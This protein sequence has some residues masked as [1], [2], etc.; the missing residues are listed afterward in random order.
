LNELSIPFEH[1]QATH[2]ESGNTANLLHFHGVELSEPMAFGIGGGIFFGYFPFIR[3]AHIRVTTFRKAPMAVFFN[4]LKRLGL[5]YKTK[6][7]FSRANARKELDRVLDSGVPVG[8]QVGFYW[9]PYVPRAMRSHF[10]AH[11]IVVYGRKDGHYTISEPGMDQPQ[12]LLPED[13]ER[14]RFAKGGMNPNGRMYWLTEDRSPKAPAL[15]WPI[16]LG[17]RDACFNMLDIPIPLLG[18]KGIRYLGKDLRK[19]KQKLPEAEVMNNL[20]QIIIMQEVVGSGGAGFR[21]MFA[22]FLLEAAQ[23]LGLPELEE[24]SHEL[25]AIGDTWRQFAVVAT[26]FVKG[27]PDPGD[28]YTAL[29]D[30]IDAIADREEALFKKLRAIVK[31]LK[32]A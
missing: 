19:W 32:K 8:C 27:R 3:M 18:V 17:I 7:F 12:R 28:T 30:M 13:L 29:A 21:Y 14:A 1:R 4:G 31:P 5:K 22:A 15:A 23:V 24:A 9:L 11:N 26:R 10:N 6:T 2:C 20:N 25:T 16:V